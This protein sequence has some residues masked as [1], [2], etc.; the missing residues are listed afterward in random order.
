MGTPAFSITSPPTAP[1]IVGS[2]GSPVLITAVGGIT[3]SKALNQLMYVAGNGGPVTVTAT[4]Q[5]AAGTIIGQIL[6]I[7]GTNN[8]NTVTIGFGTGMELNG[9]CVLA[10]ASMISLIWTGSVWTELSRNDI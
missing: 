1:L 10:L 6:M 2:F 8:T 5:I 4:P 3:A 9:N 7:K